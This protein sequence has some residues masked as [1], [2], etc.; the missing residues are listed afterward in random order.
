MFCYL[1]V[2]NSK[3]FQRMGISL[4]RNS[5][6]Y[7][8]KKTFHIKRYNEINQKS[9]F[10]TSYQNFIMM[11]RVFPAKKIKEIKNFFI[12][13]YGGL[14]VDS[15]S[16]G[17]WEDEGFVFKDVSLEY[18]IFIPK[19]KFETKVKNRFQN[20][21]KNSKKILISLQ[22]SVITTMLHLPAHCWHFEPT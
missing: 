15:L 12:S 17:Y 21:W 10:I 1:P 4:L 11:V 18:S 22:C 20:I 8:L 16:E 3:P 9:N 7:S 5:A 13:N 6:L 14:S 19:R 2:N